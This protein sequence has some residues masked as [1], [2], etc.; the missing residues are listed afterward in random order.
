[1]RVLTW[2][3][4]GLASTLQYYPWSE[5]K[6]FK[7]LLDSLES[8]IICFQEVKCQKSKLTKEMAVVPGYNAYF[9]CSKVKLGYSGVVVYVKDTLTPLRTYEGI[10]GAL[11]DI[12]DGFSYNLTTPALQLDSEGRCI[13]MDFGFFI[14]FNIYFPNESNETRTEFKMDYHDCVRQRIEKFLKEG[15]QVLLVGDVNAV[16]DEIDHCDPKESMKEHGILDFKDLPH[17]RWLD[18]ILDPKGPLIDMTRLYHP[19]R[20]KMFTCWNT[21]MNTR[22]SNLGTRIDYTLASKGLKPYFKY[23]DIQP[24]IMGSDHCPVYADF[25]DNLIADYTQSTPPQEND[26][27]SPLL[28]T[29]FPQ[30]SNQQKKLSNYFM[31]SLPSAPNNNI[32]SLPAHT[33]S[34]SI[35][36]VKRNSISSFPSNKKVKTKHTPAIHSFFTPH[37]K[38]VSP[39]AV[40]EKAEENDSFINVDEL[41][42]EAQTK[43]KTA[44]AWTSL[45]IPPEVPRC[46]V[47]NEPCLERTVSKKGPN[48][49]RVFYICAKPI[50]P[51]DDPVNN[52]QFSCNFFQWK[53]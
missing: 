25:T 5:T 20:T 41:I 8:E 18:D 7:V 53:K 45:F 32:T 33:A 35:P 14:L 29:N 44:K 15:R 42:S 10:T 23:S 17:R 47:H 21:K 38:P 4:N 40:V 28:A 9:S 27:I 39:S 12:D 19:E 24:N 43:E 6:S 1:M 50:G 22:P 31:K 30:F 2:N 46:K 3:V 11:D 26:F 49:G 51:K 37:K 52:S 13:I 16:H 34:A 48:I 36:S